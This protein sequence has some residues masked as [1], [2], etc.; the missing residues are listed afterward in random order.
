M[1]VIL[2]GLLFVAFP[3]DVP[4]DWTQ[5]SKN[6][7]LDPAC[8]PRNQI[9]DFI[10]VQAPSCDG[11][12]LCAKNLATIS[13]PWS[14]SKVPDDV[15]RPFPYKHPRKWVDPP[16]FATREKLNRNNWSPNPGAPFICINSLPA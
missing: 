7:V 9:P 11:I 2:A 16:E 6:C 8:P 10:A 4:V 3:V 14:P 12:M 1:I 5:V 15:G 13:I